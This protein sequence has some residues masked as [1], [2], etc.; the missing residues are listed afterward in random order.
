MVPVCLANLSTLTLI[1]NAWEGTCG[2]LEGRVAWRLAP[3]G[4]EL[5]EVLTKNVVVD[6]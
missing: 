5:V 2:A 1:R 3:L 6:G 4:H